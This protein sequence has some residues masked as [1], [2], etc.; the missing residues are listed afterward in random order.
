[1][2]K[3]KEHTKLTDTLTLSK[4]DGRYWLWDETR[5]MNL[6][7]GVSTQTEAFTEALTYYQNRTTKLTK[8]L[9]KLKN[10]VDTFLDS[11]CIDYEF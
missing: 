1:M 10:N 9:T 7:M 4:I 5:G 2:S 3:E 11:V 8:E 6:A